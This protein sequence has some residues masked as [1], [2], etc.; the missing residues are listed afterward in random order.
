MLAGVIILFLILVGLV[1][2]NAWP[3]SLSLPGGSDTVENTAAKSPAGPSGPAHRL[4]T[5]SVTSQGGGATA[6]EGAKGGGTPSSPG[7]GE[8]L[9]PGGLRNP[10]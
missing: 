6:T 1:T 2:F 9:R 4:A 3:D 10:R 5:N 7:S 8:F